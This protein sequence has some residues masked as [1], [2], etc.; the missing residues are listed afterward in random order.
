MSTTFAPH[1]S[2]LAQAP[3]PQIATATPDLT[4]QHA[5]DHLSHI[6]SPTMLLSVFAMLVG[7]TFV[8]VL[9]AQISFGAWEVWVSLGIAS[10]KASL[11]AVY[12]MHLRYDKP[13]NGVIFVSSIVFVA[14][15]LGLTLVDLQTH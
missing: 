9:A 6:M 15:F 11:V 10:V 4:D 8:T 12:F 13:F 5:H 1:V 7:L 2:D 3:D 14:L